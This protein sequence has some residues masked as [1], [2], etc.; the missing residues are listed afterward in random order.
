MSLSE[1]WIM[2]ISSQTL[3]ISSNLPKL[4]CAEDDE[5]LRLVLDVVHQLL[6]QVGAAG[7]L[8]HHELEQVVEEGVG[9]DRAE[10]PLQTRQDHQL[11]V[12]E[13]EEINNVTNTYTL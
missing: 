5:V 12:L 10:V 13:E 2:T 1:L 7:A 9:G 11:H 3:A 6:L 8:L 4:C